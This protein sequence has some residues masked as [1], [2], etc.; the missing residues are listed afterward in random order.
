MKGET[1][2]YR[3]DCLFITVVDESFGGDI[4]RAATRAGFVINEA[5]MVTKG[6]AATLAGCRIG[7][8]NNVLILKVE[9]LTDLEQAIDRLLVDLPLGTR[10]K[11]LK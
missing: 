11:K 8:S 2:A 5:D 7:G 10:L 3:S 6:E 9:P 4:S 1:L